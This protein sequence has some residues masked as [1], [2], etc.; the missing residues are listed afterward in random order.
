M[1]QAAVMIILNKDGLILGVSRGKDLTR[2][3][4]PGGKASNNETPKQ[5][6]L[7]EVKEETGLSIKACTQI[8]KAEEPPEAEDGETFIVHYFYALKWEG[9]PRSSEEGQVEWLTLKEMTETKPAFPE[10]IKAPFVEFKKLFPD[11]KIV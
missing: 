10:S 8:Y 4:L 5:N 9:V 6:V 1:K 7:R 11:V 2:F 3:S